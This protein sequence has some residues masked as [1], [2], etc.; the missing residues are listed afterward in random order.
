VFFKLRV[1]RKSNLNFKIF[2]L[3]IVPLLLMKFPKIFEI[4]FGMVDFNKTQ[5]SKAMKKFYNLIL[6]S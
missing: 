4:F 6:V 2:Y 1:T 5:F 3:V